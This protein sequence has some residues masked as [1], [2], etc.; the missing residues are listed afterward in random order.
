MNLFSVPFNA[1]HKNSSHINH[2]HYKIY[3]M[4][5]KNNTFGVVFYLKKYKANRGKSPIY[6]R[7][8]VDGKR[9]DISIKR[10]IEDKFWNGYKGLAKGSS[11]TRKILQSSQM[12]MMTRTFKQL[13]PTCRSNF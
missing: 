5:T 6:A 2:F 8:T 13:L 12:V 9:V 1:G 11:I 7:I 4:K 10:S 3:A